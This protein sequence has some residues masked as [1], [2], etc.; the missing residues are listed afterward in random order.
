MA[1][2]RFTPQ[3]NARVAN[4]TRARR[5]RNRA[6]RRNNNRQQPVHNT[7]R[8][9][10]RNLEEENKP[11]HSGNNQ[12]SL[13]ENVKLKDAIPPDLRKYCEAVVHPF[14]NDAVGA[15]LPDRYQEL[16]VAVTDRLELD[17]TPANLYLDGTPPAGYNLVG[18]FIWFQ[19]RCIAAGTL[20]I[21]PAAEDSFAYDPVTATGT[22]W[23]VPFLCLNDQFNDTAVDQI[24][25]AYNLCI[26]GI[27]ETPANIQGIA[28]AP[29]TYGLFTDNG[30]APVTAGGDI[31]Y[32]IW[33]GYITLPYTRFSNIENNCDKIRVLGAGIKAW[34]EEAPINTGGYS[35]GGW[36]TL[37][38][39][40]EA[41]EWGDKQRNGVG[42]TP[43]EVPGPLSPGALKAIQTKIRFAKR[44]MG[45]KGVTV[46]YSSI[47]SSKQVESQYPTIPDRDYLINDLTD[48]KSYDIPDVFPQQ[49]ESAAGGTLGKNSIETA[50]NCDLS[51]NDMMT[52][53]S[54]VPVIFW[55]FNVAN[56]STEPELYTIKVMSTVL[57]EAVPNGDCPFATTKS[58]YEPAVT[59]VK[60]MLENPEVFPAASSGNS[61]K[62]FMTKTKH[63]FAK[64]VKGAGHLQKM[65]NLVDQFGTMFAQ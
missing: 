48:S 32:H 14:G 56:G 18:M 21:L 35:V 26:T 29:V 47:Q 8:P 19:P 11:A 57:S 13:F 65:I 22:I 30:L 49:N 15:L 23:R 27:W 36:M 46:R 4:D 2:R 52:P 34:S 28:D 59:S 10:N 7:N 53:G 38:D 24:L 41:L 64:V 43:A 37:E 60:M 44:N 40:Y 25:D 51:I 61:F 12:G 33:N 39:I 45:V 5:R 63:V 1:Q 42:G 16:V 58:Q 50:Q 3:E 62:S 9:H 20:A 55:Q 6:R 17:I 31:V 54:F